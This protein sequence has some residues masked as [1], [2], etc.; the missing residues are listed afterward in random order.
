MDTRPLG[1]T[2]LRVSHI[3][4]GTV[5]IGRNT[6][7]KFPGAFSLPSSDETV[8]L[9]H[10]LLDLGITLIDT[11]PAY[12]V[13]EERLGR[14]LVGRRDEVVLCTKIGETFEHGLSHHD[15]SPAAIRA[16]LEQ[17]LTRLQTDHVDV[18]L[19]HAGDDDLAIQCSGELAGTLAELRREGKTRSIGFSGKTVPA[20]EAALGWADVVM[21]PYAMNNR[22]HEQV[23][24]AAAS[25]GVGVLLKKVLGSG[26]LPAEAAL[27]FVLQE[28]PVADSV[29]SVVIG[30]LSSD[31]MQSNVE[32][33]R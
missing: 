9:V 26:H 18:L 19:V 23:I 33:A 15:F 12:G 10:R 13:A 21:C 17:S 28:S 1:R 30:S 2:G 5:K 11:A 29:A 25:A 20:A 8:E 32:Q 16:S 27:Q 4:W 24:E 3:G 6:S 14:A 31:R 7:V 22:E